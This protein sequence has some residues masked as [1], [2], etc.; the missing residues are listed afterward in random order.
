[1]NTRMARPVSGFT[2]LT[3]LTLIGLT[4]CASGPPAEVT[5]STE[6]GVTQPSPASM[7]ATESVTTR[8][9]KARPDRCGPQVAELQ[10]RNNALLEEI[11]R[12]DA[13]LAEAQ[14]ANEDL[15]RK[16]AALRAIDREALTQQPKALTPA[17][18]E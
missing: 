3:G 2:L 8:E 4:G 11:K 18:H 15:K 13:A 17:S 12:R 16:L 7:T 5:T 9:V 10:K 6:S 1:M 14:R